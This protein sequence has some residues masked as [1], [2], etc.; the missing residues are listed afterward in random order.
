MRSSFPRFGKLREIFYSA[1]FIFT[2]S[3]ISEQVA[4]WL[5]KCLAYLA[6]PIPYKLFPSTYSL[7]CDIHLRRHYLISLKPKTNLFRLN[8]NTLNTPFHHIVIIIITHECWV[9]EVLYAVCNRRVRLTKPFCARPTM[10][11]WYLRQSTNIASF[12]PQIFLLWC[13]QGMSWLWLMW[14]QP[15]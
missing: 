12:F 7:R 9:A 15:F 11:D 1:Y 8:M 2:I 6:Y 10:G 14:Y 3:K 5:L 4:L 13:Y